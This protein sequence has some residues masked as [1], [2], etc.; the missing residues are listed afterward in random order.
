MKPM[1]SDALH[2]PNASKCTFIIIRYGEL[3]NFWT[4]FRVA[5]AWHWL[6]TGL[7][8]RCAQLSEDTIP[9]RHSLTQT[10]KIGKETEKVQLETETWMICTSCTA[11]LWNSWETFVDPVWDT[12]GPWPASRCYTRLTMAS[13]R[14]D[15]WKCFAGI[16]CVT[17]L[18][19]TLV[20]LLVGLVGFFEGPLVKLAAAVQQQNYIVGVSPRRAPE[21]VRLQ[22]HMNIFKFGSYNATAI[23]R[24]QIEQWSNLVKP[25]KLSKPWTIA[26]MKQAV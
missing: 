2:V 14:R 15:S 9:R 5:L 16:S 6:D 4:R 23:D 17:I 11:L 25:C 8:R 26:T 3:G 10:G 13:S 19:G 12:H 22:K 21:S 18:E 20:R 1:N 7:G 24:T